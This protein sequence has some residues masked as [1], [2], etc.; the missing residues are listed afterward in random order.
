M[1]SGG[2]EIWEK[3]T[4]VASGHPSAA[5]RP[6]GLGI[7]K[8]TSSKPTM[9]LNSDN[10]IFMENGRSVDL[11]NDDSG[12]A[13]HIEDGQKFRTYVGVTDLKDPHTGVNVTTSAASMAM[14]DD[15]GMVIWK[16]P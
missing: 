3:S 9:M 1:N 13:L 4:S 10:I 6:I 15:R 2:L 16:Q 7:W 5:F 11:R 14:F 8:P 12:P